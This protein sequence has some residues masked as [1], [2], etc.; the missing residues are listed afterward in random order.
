M[1]EASEAMNKVKLILRSLGESNL[2]SISFLG[3]TLRMC[4]ELEDF[5]GGEEVSEVAVSIDDS[6]ND[7]IYMVAFIKFKLGKHEEAREALSILAE[8]Q[9]LDDEIRAAAEEIE[10]ELNSL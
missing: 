10:R 5:E 9:D 4:V 1:Q 3:E 7:V 8:R 6:M 2:P